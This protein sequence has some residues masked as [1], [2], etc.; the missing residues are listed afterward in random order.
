[1]KQ[2]VMCV[3][4]PTPCHLPEN[5]DVFDMVIDLTHLPHQDGSSARSRKYVKQAVK[6]CGGCPERQQCYTVHGDDLKLG[7]IAGLTDAER[8]APKRKRGAA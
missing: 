1:M 8:G 3:D 5:L 7:V 4:E 2:L 6:L